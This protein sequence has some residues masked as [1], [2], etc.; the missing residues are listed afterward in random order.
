MAQ[1][2]F[3]TIMKKC[4]LQDMRVFR[5][6][7]VIPLLPTHEKYPVSIVQDILTHL[8]PVLHCYIPWKI[9]ENL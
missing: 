5:N 1:T 4:F 6:I 9:S 7:V 2:T 3:V 8:R